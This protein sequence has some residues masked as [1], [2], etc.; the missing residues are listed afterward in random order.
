M[1]ENVIKYVS[2]LDPILS[3][4]DGNLFLYLS[5]SALLPAVPAPHYSRDGT[6]AMEDK[7]TNWSKRG[8][9]HPCHIAVWQHVLQQRPRAKTC[10][11]GDAA[12][13]Q[14]EANAGRH[15]NTL[16]KVQLWVK[17]TIVDFWTVSDLFQLVSS[18]NMKHG[19]TQ[20]R[21][22]GVHVGERVLGVDREHSIGVS[23]FTSD[24]ASNHRLGFVASISILNKGCGPF[25]RTTQQAC[26]PMEIVGRW[27]EMGDILT[28]PK[29]VAYGFV[30]SCVQCWIPDVSDPTRVDFLG[31]TKRDFEKKV[32]KVDFTKCHGEGEFEGQVGIYMKQGYNLNRIQFGAHLTLGFDS[33]TLYNKRTGLK[34]TDDT[35]GTNDALKEMAKRYYLFRTERE[36]QP[37][38]PDCAPPRPSL[39]SAARFHRHVE[40]LARAQRARRETFPSHPRRALSSAARRRRRVVRST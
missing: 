36:E 24:M 38:P 23:R 29:R 14:A 2:E 25:T 12:L 16:K 20:L 30:V 34:M 32:M 40:R 35:L 21:L 5:A 11:A 15:S 10:V 22:D 13:R 37:P 8:I 9:L 4:L 27:C 1:R 28:F 26:E 3:F 19:D 33:S 31:E 7:Q 39:R 18:F 17:E 6:D